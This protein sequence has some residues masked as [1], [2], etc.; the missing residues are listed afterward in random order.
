[1]IKAFITSDIK[2]TYEGY[3]LLTSL[4]PVLPENCPGCGFVDDSTTWIR[5][6]DTFV[7]G[8]GCGYALQNDDIWLQVI[9]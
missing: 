4:I 1:M 5:Q 6:N 9:Q 3:E 8:F 7:C 2:L